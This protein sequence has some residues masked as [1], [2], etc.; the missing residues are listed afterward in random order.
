MVRTLSVDYAMGAAEA[1]HSHGWG[2][3]VYSARGAL[4]S[5]AD[6]VLFFL[7]PGRAL[8]IPA[9][10]A[11][12]LHAPGPVELRTLYIRP[13]ETDLPARV[14]TISVSRLLRE[15]I[16]RACMLNA[17][18][19]R[20]PAERTLANLILDE[21]REAP[22]ASAT[23]T[24]P[25]DRRARRLAQF[26]LKEG[27]E[28]PLEAACRYCALSRRTAERLFRTECNVGPGKWRRLA[29]LAKALEA[30]SRGET[31]DTATELA[32]YSSRSGFHE[33][34]VSLFGA[35]PG[36]LRTTVLENLD[37]DTLKSND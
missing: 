33:A 24:F 29:N 32:G 5:E 1:W 7:P 19:E 10:Y 16:L 3:L 22:V 27:P 11:H 20:R 15:A 12:R 6:R 13:S 18:C 17:L 31:L 2:Q 35:S 23:L 28:F 25:R 30:I 21:I 8:W 9:G 26:L 37:R 4:R 34:M 14:Q 36:K